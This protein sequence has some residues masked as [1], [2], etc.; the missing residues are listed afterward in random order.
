MSILIVGATVLPMTASAADTSKYYTG[1]VGISDGRILF[2]GPSEAVREEERLF[3]QI[4]A[5]DLT[6]LDGTDRILMP[7][8]I[9]LHNH[10]SMTLLR[11]Y[12]DDMALM[13]WLNEKIWPFEA[14][15][16]AEDV[17]WGAR[18]GIAEML[19]GGTT[20]FVD[21]Y[22]HADEVI[23]AARESGIRGVICP[24]FVG[25]NYDTFEPEA[26]RILQD[27]TLKTD[28]RIQVRIAPHAPYTCPPDTLKKALGLC[29]RF[30]VG[31]HIHVSET[32]D[33]Q[34]IIRET[35]GKTPTEYLRD[36]GLFEYPT[37]AAHCV[38]VNDSDMAIFRQYGVTVAHNPHS[39]MKLASGIA[40]VTRMRAQGVTVGFGTDGPS[41]NNDLD[42]WEEMRTGSLL[43]K[44]ATGDPCALTAYETLQMA[45]VEG[46]RALGMADELGIIVPGAR[47]DLLLIDTRRAH[48][49]P[50]H[51]WIANLA[52]SAKASDVETVIVQGKIV[53][54][55]GQFC[56][57]SLDAL[58]AEASRCVR[59][60]ESRLHA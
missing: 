33:E 58:R 31:L 60:I 4:H 50:C 22:W 13:P 56:G 35:Y 37:L 57:H 15:M 30:G 52:Y 24:T 54:R 59:A 45:T 10:V 26:L 27:P 53:V 9:N 7:G 6:I 29:E 5:D 21:M 14:K 34:Q 46:A 39:N 41:S 47:A 43:Q 1:T 49:T 3:R 18:L 32:Q 12:A 25:S 19:L 44:V 48:L 8:L 2:A 42:M 36:I 16:T 11:G 38:Y 20:T 55:E 40:P 51:D 17:Y 28:D 23:R